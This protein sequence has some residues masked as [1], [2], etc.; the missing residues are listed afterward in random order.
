MAYSV[1]TEYRWRYFAARAGYTY[2]LTPIPDQTVNPLL[3]DGN[4][5]WFSAGL[6]LTSS[7]WG[8]DVA[9]QL[10][11]FSRV[12]DNAIGE[13]FNSASPPI[14]ARANGRY[15]AHAHVVSGTLSY[16]FLSRPPSNNGSGSW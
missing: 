16:V 12:K 8:L 10:I 4:R 7:G 9:Y 5:Q 13:R 2:D 15:R 3:P 14:D 11:T 1:G 6:G